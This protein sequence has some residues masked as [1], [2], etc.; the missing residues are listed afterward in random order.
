MILIF[1]IKLETTITACLPC[2]ASQVT[3]ANIY[4]LLLAIINVYQIF[5]TEDVE[6]GSLPASSRLQTVTKDIMEDNEDSDCVILDTRSS[7]ADNKYKHKQS[8]IQG[9]YG[10]SQDKGSPKKSDSNAMKKHWSSQTDSL[11]LSDGSLSGSE[12][13][14]EDSDSSSVSSVSSCPKLTGEVSSV[15]SFSDEGCD[16]NSSSDSSSA[17]DNDDDSPPPPLLEPQ[18]PELKKRKLKENLSKNVVLKAKLKD[19]PRPK[20]MKNHKKVEC[21]S[22]TEET[23]FPRTIL[24][25]S[26][27]S[28]SNLVQSKESYKSFNSGPPLLSGFGAQSS[29]LNRG[30]PRKNPPTL[31]PQ[32]ETKKDG[33]TSTSTSTSTL[34]WFP[35]DHSESTDETADEREEKLKKKDKLSVLFGAAKHWQRQQENFKTEKRYIP[36]R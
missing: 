3:L 14:E 9:I 7:L 11:N 20:N 26:S 28:S 15:S 30:R 23:A 6:M 13:D 21:G 35:G 27:S 22:Q 25:S 18:I 33:F 1:V 36:K 34:T 32:I 31:Q 17:A 5:L 24:P 4:Y 29:K 16:N 12:E 10:K 2:R 19:R 8:F